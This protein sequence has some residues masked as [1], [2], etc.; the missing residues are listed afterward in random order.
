MNCYIEVNLRLLLEAENLGEPGG[1]KPPIIWAKPQSPF[2]GSENH[3]LAPNVFSMAPP[4]GENADV[5][6]VGGHRVREVDSLDSS[7]LEV[8]LHD[9]ALYKST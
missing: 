8:V 6:A 3:D 5:I 9:D 1:H 2:I 7:A 4:V